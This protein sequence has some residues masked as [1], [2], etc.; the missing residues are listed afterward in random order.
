MLPQGVSQ[1][2]SD[3]KI[4]FRTHN[5]VLKKELSLQLASQRLF[6]HDAIHTYIY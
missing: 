5:I 4:K 2:Y 6:L 3:N 1:T